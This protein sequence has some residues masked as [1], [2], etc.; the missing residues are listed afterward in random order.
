MSIKWL[1]FAGCLLGA[2]TARAEETGEPPSECQGTVGEVRFEGASRS[3]RAYLIDVTALHAGTPCDEDILRAARQALMDTELFHSVKM[4]FRETPQGTNVTFIIKEKFYWL[5]LPRIERSSDGEISVGG[6]LKAYHLWGLNHTLDLT[7]EVSRQDEGAGN[8]TYTHAI[9]YSAPRLVALDYGFAVAGEWENSERKLYLGG[10]VIGE[11]DTLDEGGSIAVR[12]W[13]TPRR[14]DER[15][16]IDYGFRWKDREFELLRGDAGDHRGGQ[17]GQF[18]LG[19]GWTDVHFGEYRRTG[20]QAQIIA[21]LSRPGTNSDFNYEQLRLVWR[22]YKALDWHYLD[23]LNTQVVMGYSSGNAFG[24][25][26]FSLGGSSF[27]RGL[28]DNSDHG[29]NMLQVNFQ[30]LSALKNIPTLRWGGFIDTGN[31]YPK[32]SYRLKDLEYSLGASL[33]WKVRWLVRTDIRIDAGYHP[34]S[35]SGKAYLGTSVLF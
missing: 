28:E 12:H 19:L 4:D 2:L 18:S 20:R 6:Q 25:E 27:I 17:L 14:S 16:S 34:Q 11:A 29:F 13:L 15:L 23:N 7:S 3:Q 5:P 8:K 31:V 30:Y 32:D 26:T 22:E 35:N 9:E 24:A 33:R 10:E 21:S 1:L